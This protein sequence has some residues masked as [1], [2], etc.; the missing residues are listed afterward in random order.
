MFFSS[1]VVLSICLLAKFF[2]NRFTR[3]RH[4]KRSIRLCGPKN[5]FFLG[6][7]VE[8]WSTRC[9]SQLLT[10]WTKI[11]GQ[12]FVYFEGQTPVFVSSDVEFLQNVFE[13]KFY[14]NFVE[15]KKTPFE[16]QVDENLT[17][18]VSANG[19]SWKHQ[20]QIINPAFSPS[21]LK[22]I[23]PTI[24]LCLDQFI[25]NISDGKAKHLDIFP[26]LKELSLDVLRKFAFPSK[27]NSR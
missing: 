16:R 19:P 2:F 26:K 14:S 1:F 22:S 23:S 20:R 24:Q 3:H 11:Y 12:T 8:L 18:L 21:N 25:K 10:S 5:V 13:R 9:F 4:L 7:V 17:N 6:S 27:K 15:R